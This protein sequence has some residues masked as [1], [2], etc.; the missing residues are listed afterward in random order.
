M[1]HDFTALV[2]PLEEVSA[3]EL[4]QETR[5]RLKEH[6]AAVVQR[7]STIQQVFPCSIRDK[8]NDE[9]WVT[10]QLRETEERSAAA[11]LQ[12]TTLLTMLSSMIGGLNHVNSDISH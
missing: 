12:R 9:A 3:L 10:E 6:I 2:P 4:L 1:S 11:E 7:L 8:L 5:E